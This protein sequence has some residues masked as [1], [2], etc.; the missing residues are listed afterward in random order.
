M[1]DHDEVM[2]RLDWC[3]AALK[4]L[5]SKDAGWQPEAVLGDLED[6]E[7]VVPVH[8]PRP[9]ACPHNQQVLV[10]GNVRCARCGTVLTASGVRGRDASSP[11]PER[12]REESLN[13]G[14]SKNPGSPLVPY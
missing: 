3:V 7:W 5:L 13:H 2:K 9:K 11:V 12:G 14:S 1:S 6:E 10:D 4:Y 8:E